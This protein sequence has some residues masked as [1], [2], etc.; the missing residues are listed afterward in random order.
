[1]LS[2]IFQQPS[3]DN[4][5]IEWVDRNLPAVKKVFDREHLLL[6]HHLNLNLKKQTYFE[7][8]KGGKVLCK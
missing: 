7:R 1:M 6:L 8:L 4:G 3:I 2:R 5:F